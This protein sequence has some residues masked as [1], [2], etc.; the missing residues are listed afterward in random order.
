MPPSRPRHRRCLRA[1]LAGVGLA[2]LCVVPANS[3][4][5]ET[6]SPGAA[7]HDS[8]TG[9]PDALEKAR[10]VR[11]R[12]NREGVASQNRIDEIS[13]RTDKLFARYTAAL[14]QLDSVRAYNHRMEE[15]VAEQEEE[16]ADLSEQ[17]DR[18]QQVGRRVTPLMLNMI[19]ALDEFVQLDVPFLPEERAARIA[20]LRSMMGR[21]DVS[22]AEKFRQ[23]MDAYQTENEYGRTI[24]AYR[25]DLPRDGRTI[26]VDFLRFG[27]IALVYETL[28]GSEVGAWNQ[29]TRS[30]E[31]LDASYRAD[32]RRAIRMARKQET[33]D[34]VSLPLPEPR[35]TG[36]NG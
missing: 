18:V 17:L 19:D 4:Q 12:G 13:D 5:E 20:E 24:E 14:S 22:T 35:D 1:G 9:K 15:L 2:L 7:V 21:S 23:I 31:P 26:T 25:G 30:W 32:I 11:R 33:P 34:L 16:L 28:D 10:E 27:R 8:D 36:G 3:V 29:Q 6:T